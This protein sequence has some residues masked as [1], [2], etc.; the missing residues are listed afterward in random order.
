[1]TLLGWSPVEGMDELFTL[2]D[3][4]KV[5]S[6]D[7]VNRAGAKFD[8]DKLN[9]INSQYIH[10]MAVPA[11]T[12]LLIPYWQDAGYEFDAVADR[13]WLEQ[14]VAVVGPSIAT[15]PE[16][17]EMVEYLFKQTVT[18]TEDATKQLIL[19]GVKDALAAV[20]AA[21]PAEALTEETA[22]AI[23]DAVVKEKGVKKGLV[24]KSLR[25]GL[26]G[27]LKGPD[28]MQ[29]WLMLNAKGWDKTRL[30]GAIA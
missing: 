4:S 9:W 17:T 13:S 15:L 21:I 8:W 25:A 5:F 1:M 7:R 16:A 30:E 27:S 23:V 29:S 19:D 11:L 12:D 18:P 10:A 24:M 22:K 3:V 28:L 6:F 2:E 20:L 14:L 26:T